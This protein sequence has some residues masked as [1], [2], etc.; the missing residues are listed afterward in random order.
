MPAENGNYWETD[1][2]VK[3]DKR[4]RVR[5]IAFSAPGIYYNRDAFGLESLDDLQRSLINVI[6]DNDIIPLVDKQVGKTQRINC[7]RQNAMY[8]HQLYQTVCELW[9]GCGD[10]KGRDYRNVCGKFM[11]AGEKAAM[12]AS[13][14]RLRK[15]KEQTGKDIAGGGGT[16]FSFADVVPREVPSERHI[17][18]REPPEPAGSEAFSG[19]TDQAKAADEEE[20]K[21]EKNTFRVDWKK[22]EK[23]NDKSMNLVDA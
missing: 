19:F 9:R 13:V 1:K 3:L 14:E 21:E 4:I 11:T 18:N 16:T 2:C 7:D 15:Q 6:P 8:C 5:A 12:K 23:K 10:P 22:K 17:R 20:G